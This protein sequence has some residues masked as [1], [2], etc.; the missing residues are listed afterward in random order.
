MSKKPSACVDVVFRAFP[1]GDVIAL[2]P[3]ED[4]GRGQ[5]LSYQRLGQHGGADRALI[6]ELRS[7]SRKEYA[8]LLAEL[9]KIGYCLRVRR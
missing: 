6:K 2:F 4:A 7:A 3:G 9:K 8:P 1:E 5:V